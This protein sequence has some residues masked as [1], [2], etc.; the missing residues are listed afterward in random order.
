MQSRQY[1]NLEEFL[2]F[3]IESTIMGLMLLG[4]QNA[5][6]KTVNFQG[7]LFYAP[8]AKETAFEGMTLL[9]DLKLQITR[10]KL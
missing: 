10:I 1:V 8:V 4:F 6:P 3:Y 7:Y 2:D 5:Q 9:V